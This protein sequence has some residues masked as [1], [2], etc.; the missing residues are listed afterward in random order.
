MLRARVGGIG[1]GGGAV[2]ESVPSWG[3]S[4][5]PD[6]ASSILMSF[7]VAFTMVATFC[8]PLATVARSN[9]ST[10]WPPCLT[11]SLNM[12]SDGESPPASTISTSM[13]P[14]L[15][16]ASSATTRR[17]PANGAWGAD[18]SS[19]RPSPVPLP[20]SSPIRTT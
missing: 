19:L 2:R 6:P 7:E 5:A 1:A 17:R 13:S 18:E 20:P 14:G 8:F 9:S 3:F 16:A 15:L 10:T 4:S 12:S 11:S